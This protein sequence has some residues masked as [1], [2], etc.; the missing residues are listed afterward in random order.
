MRSVSW[1]RSWVVVSLLGLAACGPEDGS[2]MDDSELGTAEAELQSCSPT[3]PQP[4]GCYYGQYCGVN[5]YCEPVAAP[6]CQNFVAHGTSWNP[7]T[8]LGPVIYQSGQ[9]YFGPDGVWCSPNLDRIIIRLKAYSPSGNL[10]T[11]RSGFSGWLRYVRMDGGI[12][13]ASSLVTNVNTSADRR[14]TTFDT[15]LCVYPG[16]TTVSAG[17]YFV[18]G[19][20]HCVQAVK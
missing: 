13:D 3:S 19:N 10:P 4:A 5:A 8:S 16:T 1:S 14:T 17:F 15:N 18:D 7:N 9:V 12:V 2:G 6:T 11:S 20:E